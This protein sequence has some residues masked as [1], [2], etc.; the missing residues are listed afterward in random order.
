MDGAS[1]VQA[2]QPARRVMRRAFRNNRLCSRAEFH[3]AFRFRSGKPAS[4]GTLIGLKCPNFAT[5]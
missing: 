3:L 4:K 1:I 2:A 5:T